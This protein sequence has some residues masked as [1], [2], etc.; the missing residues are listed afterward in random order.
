M[1]DLL[2]R[3]LAPLTE[4][5]WK[6][7]DEAAA[8]MLKSHLT[9]RA[10][11]DFDGPRGW[12]FAAVNLGR[13]DIA[14]KPATNDVPWG[15][16]L[17][18][19]LVETRVPLK[20]LQ[21]ELDGIARG[22]KDADLQPLEDAARRAAM[23]EES[24]VYNGFEPGGIE[25]ILTQSAH[26]SIVLPTN[27]QEFPNAVAGALRELKLAG[28]EGPFSLVLGTE[29]W[30]GLMQSGAGGYPPQRIIQR[31]IN[32]EIRMSPVIDGGVLLS[33]AGGYFELTVGQDFSIGYGGHD[34]EHAA[35]ELYLTES[36]TFRV[37]EPKAAVR[38]MPG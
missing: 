4:Q 36:F 5:T 17:V 32:G 31:L 3:S 25:G 23:F 26:Q 22:A 20:M 14:K 34:H 33:A 6:D 21:M 27:I 12:D 16:R 10:I 30:A 11:V 37:L 7:V 28:I 24:A 13:L 29:T 19:P 35:V 9:A 1:V 38:L 2:R 15:K 18:L 8:R